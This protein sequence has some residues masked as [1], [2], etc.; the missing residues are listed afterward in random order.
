MTLSS[1]RLAEFMRGSQTALIVGVLAA[2]PACWGSAF[3]TDDDAGADAGADGSASLRDA[4]PL[5]CATVLHCNSG[6]PTCCLSTVTQPSCTS[7]TC[8]CVTAL[9][10]AN[11]DNCGS[12]LVCCLSTV[13]PG[14]DCS[15]N[16]FVSTCES[17]C[18][19]GAA[20]LCDPTAPACPTGSCASDTATLS[21]YGIL[22]NVGYGVCTSP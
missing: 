17:A 1:D 10:C 21:L 7:G 16:H 6:A 19:S 13:A 14:T 8:G 3:L 11:D 12:G 18:A 20:R 5:N 15:G 4:S 22:P 2:L 9:T